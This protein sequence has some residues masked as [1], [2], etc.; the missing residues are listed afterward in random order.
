ME[1]YVI[2]KKLRINSQNENSLDNEKK[3][4]KYALVGSCEPGAASVGGTRRPKKH[5]R[6]NV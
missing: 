2:C 4:E 6:R 1:E 3:E 5:Y